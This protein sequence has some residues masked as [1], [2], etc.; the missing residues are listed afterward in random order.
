MESITG[1]L[2][3]KKGREKPVKNQHPWVF[4]GAIDR[5]EGEAAAGSLVEILDSHGR[6]LATGYFNPSSQIR[7]R[8]LSWEADQVINESFWRSW[9]QRAID[10]RLALNFDSQ[11]NANRLVN[12]EADGLPGLIVDRY[13]EVLVMQCLTLGIDQRKLMLARL[14]ADIIQPSGIYERSDMAV[15]Q[16]EGLSRHSGLLWGKEPEDELIIT[17]NGLQFIVD[18]REGH[19]TGYYLDQRNNRSILQRSSYIA[20]KSV[21]NVF[22]YTG[23]FS[24]CAAAAGAERITNVD[25]SIP[26]LELAERNMALNKFSRPADEY[27]AGDAFEVLRHFRDTNRQFDLIILDPP[28]FAHTKSDVNRASRGY[29]DLNWLALGLLERG[30]LLMT[31]SCSGHVS[32]DLFQKILFSAVIDANRFVQI[33]QRLGQSADHPVSLTFP[34]SSYLKGFLCRVW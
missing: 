3:L 7:A 34:E 29:K 2:I 31:Y 14:L 33:I 1:K 11:S 18:I 4:S 20:Q 6:F 23:S 21:L 8:I 27:I 10:G 32:E 28:K 9:I 22:A 26:A 25:S 17:E 16:K 15:R 24:V 12:A 13:G 30:G 19:K 5:V